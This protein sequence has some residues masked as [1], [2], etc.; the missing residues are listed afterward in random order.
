MAGSSDRAHDP[1]RREKHFR[2]P[3]H[4]THITSSHFR[5][6]HHKTQIT[7]SH[8]RAPLKTQITSSHSRAPPHKTHMT[9]SH[10]RAP[11]KPT[12]APHITAASGKDITFP[13]PF[14]AMLLPATC[15]RKNKATMSVFYE[16][17]YHCHL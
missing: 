4:Q 13:A 5:A 6:P 1:V 12:L 17:K 8:F 9:S 7:S 14:A 15:I 3:P 16:G 10:S 11:H 2:A